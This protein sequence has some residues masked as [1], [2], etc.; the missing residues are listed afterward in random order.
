MV[1][2][3]KQLDD[4][5]TLLTRTQHRIV[6]AEVGLR[7][8]DGPRLS[9][10]ELNR[11]RQ[12]IQKL[13]QQCSKLQIACSYQ[14]MPSLTTQLVDVPLKDQFRADEYELI[15]GYFLEM[16]R[17]VN[18]TYQEILR[19]GEIVNSGVKSN[20]GKWWKYWK[21]LQL[22]NQMRRTQTTLL[23]IKNDRKK[24]LNIVDKLTAHY[25]DIIPKADSTR[26]IISVFDRI[27][28]TTKEICQKQQE[29]KIGAQK[30]AQMA[31]W[32]EMHLLKENTVEVIQSLKDPSPSGAKADRA[33]IEQE[34]SV[35]R[36]SLIGA[37][38]EPVPQKVMPE[39]IRTQGQRTEN[40]HTLKDRKSESSFTNQISNEKELFADVRAYLDQQRNSNIGELPKNNSHNRFRQTLRTHPGYS[41][42]RISKTDQ[43]MSYPKGSKKLAENRNTLD[44][45]GKQP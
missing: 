28:D 15:R 43:R 19:V 14:D 1:A 41:P 17:F 29:I 24:I 36:E 21:L 45:G 9:R 23:G 4:L 18:S 44:E 22:R 27:S 40:L 11:R 20:L 25:S 13:K 6:C 30:N 10:G 35:K 2:K 38:V 39:I 33:E 32:L 37:R 16:H 5:A 26:K 8:L 3:A 12:R 42:S 31:K 34:I 7:E